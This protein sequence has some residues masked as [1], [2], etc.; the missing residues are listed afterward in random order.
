MCGKKY[1]MKKFS[2][3]YTSKICS[4]EVRHKLLR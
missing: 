1:S 3:I 4:E 2:C